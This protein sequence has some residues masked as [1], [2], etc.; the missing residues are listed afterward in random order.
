VFPFDPSI[1]TGKVTRERMAHEHPLEYAR[2]REA[3]EFRE[4]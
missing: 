2:L 3:E 1:F 4:P